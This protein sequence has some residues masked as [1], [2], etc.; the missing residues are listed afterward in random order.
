M[1]SQKKRRRPAA[2]AGASPG[3]ARAYIDRSAG[4]KLCGATRK[5]LVSRAAAEP[6]PAK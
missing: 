3:A 2:V 5:K 6:A 4:G 1:I